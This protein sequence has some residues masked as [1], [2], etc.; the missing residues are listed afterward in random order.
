M[1]SRGFIPWHWLLAVCL[2]VG[3]THPASAASGSESDPPPM[4][5]AHSPIDFFREMLAMNESQR[6]EALNHRSSRQQE[7]LMAKLAEYEAMPDIER[8][9]RLEVT[10]LHYYLM[11]LLKESAD[12]RESRLKAIPSGKRLRVL[13]RLKQWDSLTSSVQ[14]QLLA[15][16]QVMNWFIRQEI[17]WKVPPPLPRSPLRLPFP[18]NQRKFSQEQAQRMEG[19]FQQFVELPETEQKRSLAGLPGDQRKRILQAA[20]EL[21]EMPSPVRRKCINSYIEIL[22]MSKA[23]QVAI[24]RKVAQWQ[25]LSLEEKHALRSFVPQVPPLPPG[26]QSAEFPPLPPH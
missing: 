4:P 26:L 24:M 17:E 19:V 22:A 18:E 25:S 23:E 15:N 9:V 13:R 21:S 5:L 16:Q 3:W 10:E 20:N 2:Q 14:Q 12:Q 11:P 8:E 7:V 1:R 6:Q